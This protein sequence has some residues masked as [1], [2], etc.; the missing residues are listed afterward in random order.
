MWMRERERE[1][2]RERERERER[3]SKRGESAVIE[4]AIGKKDGG[5]T[6]NSLSLSF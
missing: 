1:K 6:N 3:E 2:E 4:Y 5:A